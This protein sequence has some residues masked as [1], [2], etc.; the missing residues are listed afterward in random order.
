MS[1]AFAVDL[2]CNSS[3]MAADLLPT[4]AHDDQTFQIFY[5]ADFCVAIRT[6]LGGHNLLALRKNKSATLEIYRMLYV[7][8]LFVYAKWALPSAWRW[9]LGPV[10]EAA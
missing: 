9:P 5:M 4:H 1:H 8:S 3:M 2:C 10:T 7:Q 6:S